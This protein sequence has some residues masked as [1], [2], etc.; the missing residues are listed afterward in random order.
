MAMPCLTPAVW[1]P[2]SIINIKGLCDSCGL[3]QK[4]GMAYEA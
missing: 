3:K 4:G 2:V 1:C